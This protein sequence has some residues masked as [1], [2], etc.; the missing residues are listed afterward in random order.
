MGTVVHVRNS[1]NTTHT[2]TSGTPDAP[3]G[4]FDV[5]LAG[6]GA[7]GSFT[8]DKPGTYTFFCRIHNSMTGQ[9]VVS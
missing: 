3:T 5:K 2:V 8:L 4:A 7:T 9:I 1:D 6:K